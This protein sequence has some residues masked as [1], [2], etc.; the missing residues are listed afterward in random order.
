[1]TPV[2]SLLTL[3][4][5]DTGAVNTAGDEI[6]SMFSCVRQPQQQQ[7]PVARHTFI[8][9]QELYQLQLAATLSFSWRV[10]EEKLG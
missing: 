5:V 1:M 4:S 10:G 2:S 6:L 3:L 7:Q 9:T 8:R